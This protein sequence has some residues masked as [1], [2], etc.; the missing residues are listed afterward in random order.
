MGSS[1]GAIG[2][3]VVADIG[4]FRVKMN[5]YLYKL[6]WND[7]MTQIMYDKYWA[8]PEMSASEVQLRKNSMKMQVLVIKFL[9][10]HL[11]IQITMVWVI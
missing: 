6:Q 2:T 4:G 10:Q 11:M 7:R 9:F 5:A 3:A 8:D 1:L